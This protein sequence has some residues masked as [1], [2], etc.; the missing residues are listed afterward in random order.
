[1]R[2]QGIE[3]DVRPRNGPIRSF[4]DLVAWQKAFQLASL[5][6]HATRTFPADERFGLVQQLRRGA[7]SVSSN[8]AEGYGRGGRSDY[9]RFLKMSRGSLYEIDT[10]LMLSKEL[11]FLAEAEYSSV[12]AALDECERVL[13]GLIRAIDAGPPSP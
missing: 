9:S 11:G 12:K 7:V 1:M 6:Y 4:Q 5:V 3:A 10:Q 13:A 8:I 2:D